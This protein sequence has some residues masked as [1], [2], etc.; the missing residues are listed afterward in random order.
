MYTNKPVGIWNRGWWA[1][2]LLMVIAA[3]AFTIVPFIIEI[4][5]PL[6]NFTTIMGL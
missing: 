3:V 1:L 2:V 5:Q 4:T 6:V